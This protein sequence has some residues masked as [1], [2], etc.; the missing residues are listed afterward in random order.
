MSLVG[1]LTAPDK[2]PAHAETVCGENR[3]VMRRPFG[4]YAAQSMV[5]IMH[6]AAQV[7]GGGVRSNGVCIGM[8]L[9]SIRRGRFVCI[10]FAVCRYEEYPRE[11]RNVFLCRCLCVSELRASFDRAPAGG[12]LVRRP[13]ASIAGKQGH[14]VKAREAARQGVALT[15]CAL[16]APMQ[17]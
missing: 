3:S 4:L 9:R 8:A 14:L 11:M 1:I 2:H 13:Q 15:R 17:V 6:M 10:V 12:F 5:S 7:S 16:P